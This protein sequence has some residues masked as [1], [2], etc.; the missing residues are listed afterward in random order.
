MD[1]QLLETIDEQKCLAFLAQMV[2]HKSYSATPGETK[3]AKFMVAQMMS[4]GLDAKLHKV[5]T[6]R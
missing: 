5:D 3:L 1:H 6:D 2:K 4:I